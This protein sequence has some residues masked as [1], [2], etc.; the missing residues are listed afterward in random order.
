MILDLEIQQE[1]DRTG[2]GD[3]EETAKNTT[4]RENGQD[5]ETCDPVQLEANS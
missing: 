5:V 3:V 1:E 4:V 2:Y